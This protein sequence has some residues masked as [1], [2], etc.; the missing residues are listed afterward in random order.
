ML[1]FSITHVFFVLILFLNIQKY[2][3][4]NTY[5]C[6]IKCELPKVKPDKA[7]KTTTWHVKTKKHP[8]F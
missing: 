4:R 3:M 8:T 7:R 5:K 6:H 2:A 1:F